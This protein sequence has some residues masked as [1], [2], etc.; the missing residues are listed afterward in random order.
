MKENGST[1]FLKAAHKKVSE[2]ISK[3]IFD[4]IT[5]NIVTEGDN[6][7][8]LLWYTKQKI[9]VQ[10]SEIYKYKARLSIYGSKMIPGVHYNQTYV[11]VAF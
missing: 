11:P 9:W 8:F 3:G 5:N 6:P 1:Q 7:L 2:S 4:M 10:S